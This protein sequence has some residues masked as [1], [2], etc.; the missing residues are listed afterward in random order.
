[1][2]TKHFILFTFLLLFVTPLSS[3][4]MSRE[5]GIR[6]SGLDDFDFIYKKSA[7][8]LKYKRYRIAASSLS[9]AIVEDTR[10]SFNVSY[11][12]GIEK[13]KN[14]TNQLKFIHGWEPGVYLS[15]AYS[16]D[17]TSGTIGIFLGYVL[18]FQYDFS[19]KF[20]VNIETIPTLALSTNYTDEDFGEDVLINAGFN[21]REAALTLAYKFSSPARK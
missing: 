3:Q 9:L 18:G 16:E 2:N 6:F 8:G 17:F 1:M 19:D 11:A 14:V 15:L 4:N 13:R 21:S 10:L 5:I 12:R 7:D 20:Y